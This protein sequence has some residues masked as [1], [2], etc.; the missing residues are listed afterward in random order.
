M[1]IPEFDARKTILP[2][3]LGILFLVVGLV[4]SLAYRLVTYV[5]TQISRSTGGEFELVSADSIRIVGLGF[6]IL[7]IALLVV[8]IYRLIQPMLR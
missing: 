7:G 6:T 4:A 3:V 8:V 5:M 2:A 1:P